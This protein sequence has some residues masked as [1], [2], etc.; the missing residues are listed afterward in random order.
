MSEGDLAVDL[1]ASA[2]FS[3]ELILPMIILVG[4]AFWVPYR[5]A[6]ELPESYPALAWNLC[7]SV[8]TIWI[9]ACL[10]VSILYLW[11]GFS[12]LEVFG[13]GDHVVWVAAQ[14]ALIWLPIVLLQL[15]M[16]PQHWRPDL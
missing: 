10:I 16:Q 11:Q 5:L 3:V 9:F 8:L 14:T 6:Q 13:G 1:G 2:L 4:A 12:I 7:V 15:A